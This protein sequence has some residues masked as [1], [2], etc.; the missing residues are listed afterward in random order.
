[1][2][3]TEIKSNIRPEISEAIAWSL[4]RST[5]YELERLIEDH[6]KLAYLLTLEEREAICEA[7]KILEEIQDIT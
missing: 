4:F 3:K 7:W 5:Q 1:M 2:S 6:H